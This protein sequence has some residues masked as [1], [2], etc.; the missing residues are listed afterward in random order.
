MYSFFLRQTQPPMTQAPTTKPTNG[1]P[2]TQPGMPQT[3]IR[4][5]PTM[6]PVVTNPPPSMWA[7]GTSNL[8]LMFVMVLANLAFGVLLWPSAKTVFLVLIISN[9][10][11]VFRHD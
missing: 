11:K 6:G 9:G 7:T 5:N 1:M 10:Q 2:Q 3:T 8:C 4:P